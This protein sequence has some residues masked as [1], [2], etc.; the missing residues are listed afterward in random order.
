M[1]SQ[2][3]NGFSSG[4]CQYHLYKISIHYYTVWVIPN[5]TF[6]R[7]IY[8]SWLKLLSINDKH[9]GISE[10]NYNSLQAWRILFAA[11][12]AVLGRLDIY[13]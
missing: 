12:D 1:R 13:G 4:R 7:N 9:D 5:R 10:E 6:K 11:L 3:A 2:M 8:R